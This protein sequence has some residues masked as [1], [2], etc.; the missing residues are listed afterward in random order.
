MNTVPFHTTGLP[1]VSDS[2]WVSI[3]VSQATEPSS[4]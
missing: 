1:K 4:R 2:A 3:V